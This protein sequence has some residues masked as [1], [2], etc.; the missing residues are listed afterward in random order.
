MLKLFRKPKPI[1]IKPRR[2]RI[3]LT[4]EEL[5]DLIIDYETGR[6]KDSGDPLILF[7]YADEN[8]CDRFNWPDYHYFCE[9]GIID[10]GLVNPQKLKEYRES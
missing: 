2:K 9:L 10:E 5:F 7:C 6:I 3:T 4:E 1:P 8:P